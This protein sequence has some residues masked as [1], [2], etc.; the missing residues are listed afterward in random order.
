MKEGICVINPIGVNSI[1]RY[2]RFETKK[3]DEKSSFTARETELYPLNYKV[4]RAFAGMS[5]IT[6][7]N[8]AKP[9]EVTSLYDKKVEGKDHL[10]LP[11]IHVYE[12]PDT[13]LQVFIDENP[14][15]K[16]YASR[17]QVKLYVNGDYQKNESLIKKEI[18][19]RLLNKL[20]NQK[21]N[22]TN[23]VKNNQGFYTL[24]TT[25]NKT[26][27]EKLQE[28]NKIINTPNFTQQDLNDIKNDLVKEIQL[29]NKKMSPVEMLAAANSDLRSD[30]DVIEEIKNIKL[31]DIKK[32]YK[33]CINNS[34]A[35]YYITLDKEFFNKNKDSIFKI[36]NN[37]IENPYLRHNTADKSTTT[38][39]PND[40]EKVFVNKK[41]DSLVELYYPCNDTSYRDKL[42]CDYTNILANFLRKPYITED[43][44][45]QQYSLP[46]TLNSSSTFNNA[47]LNFKFNPPK[48]EMKNFVNIDNAIM[49]EKGML[50]DLFKQD[51]KKELEGIKSYKKEFWQ[52][53]L[54]NEF[55]VNYNNNA[56]YNLGYNLFNLYEI[57][58]SIE[59]SDIKQAIS[60]YVINQK[61]VIVINGENLKEVYNENCA[62]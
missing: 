43:S 5:G 33:E 56:L 55:D 4:G 45:T 57:N 24:V 38:F 12:F 46:I 25:V 53:A 62:S 51:F 16:K 54:N 10:D 59:A 35:Q 18:C 47:F 2:S 27:C 7:K 29:S 20:V 22:N 37:N 17:I 19:V 8:L 31:N 34:E 50:Y 58:D 40:K 48:E 15:M 61:P 42:I 14:N 39:H 28:F 49:V 13:N 26:Q 23:V 60:K 32:Y 30:N 21:D 41:N 9:V 6:F 52:N 36:L 44:L 3:S 1:N 11:N